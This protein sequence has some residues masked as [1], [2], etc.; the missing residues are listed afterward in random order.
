MCLFRSPLQTP[1]IFLVYE[2]PGEL[3]PEEV[4]LEQT[5]CNPDILGPDGGRSS[6]RVG[7][8]STMYVVEL[9]QLRM[10][11]VSTFQTSP[12][13]LQESLDLVGPVAGNVLMVPVNTEGTETMLCY[14]A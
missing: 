2:Q 1:F 14:F 3:S 9:R 8:P 4:G 10:R 13:M 11:L 6:V 5:G 12:R 7:K